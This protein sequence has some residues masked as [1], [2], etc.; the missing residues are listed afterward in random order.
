M[1]K[2]V[3]AV[4]LLG[5]CANDPM[6]VPSPMNLEAG[7]MDPAGN[8]VTQAKGSLTLP[9][10]TETTD[11]ANK[12]MALA[13]QLGVMVPYVKVDDIAVEVAYTIKNPCPARIA[14]V[15]NGWTSGHAHATAPAA[16]NV[17]RS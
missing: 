5:G 9:I 8:M 4:S 10:K 2:L 13:M 1:R 17:T 3:L 15:R 16:A 11:D 6:Y 12:R 7:M 14:P